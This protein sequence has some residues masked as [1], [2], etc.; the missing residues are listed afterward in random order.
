MQPISLQSGKWTLGATLA[1]ILILS[2][3]NLYGQAQKP[4]PAS[5]QAQSAQPAAPPVLQS[6]TRSEPALF[7]KD[8]VVMTVGNH[9]FTVA[10]FNRIL[11]IFPPQ[12]RNYYN[13]PGRRK[14]AED[15]SQLLILADEARRQKLEEDLTVKQRISLLTDQSLAQS[16]IQ[17][18]Q[19]N[20]KISEEE[21]QKYYSAHAND[22]EELGA[23]HILIRVK[24]SPAPLIEG[25]KEL[26]EEEAKAKA[27][28]IYKQVTVPGTDFA[29]I[30]KA[31]SYDQG[32]ASRGGELGLF[33]HGQMVPAFEAAALAL[34]PGE[35]SR[36]VRT[37]FG[38][39]IIR[40]EEKKV[41]PLQDVKSDI[42]NL[43]RRQKVE[44]SIDS[45][46]K[47][48][49]VELNDQ[50]FPPPPPPIPPAAAPAPAK[51]EAPPTPPSAPPAEKKK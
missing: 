25:K 50:F 1:I 45:L 26:T 40:L 35:I 51:P 22:Y 31:E 38:Y 24:G 42:E 20:T 7:P 18:I 11:E 36:P 15:F 21:L 44:Q 41:K 49:K 3:P 39:H 14:F 17:Q 19:E 8:L 33:R 10:D 13:G 23:S 32:S 46:K 27:E 47:S 16:L 6:A 43:L 5:P 34:K 4:A 12:Q 9:K 2:V 37:Q 48:G 29:A 28:G 30:A